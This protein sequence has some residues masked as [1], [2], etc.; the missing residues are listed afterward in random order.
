[1]PMF[2]P[3]SISFKKYHDEHHRYMGSFIYTLRVTTF[4][5][6]LFIASV[7]RVG[8][9]VRLNEGRAVRQNRFCSALHENMFHLFPREFPRLRGGEGR[10][11]RTRALFLQYEGKNIFLSHIDMFR[12]R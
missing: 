11:R 10:R 1:M 7:L 2:V 3:I 9:V 8:C 5:L 6:L 12:S 4:G